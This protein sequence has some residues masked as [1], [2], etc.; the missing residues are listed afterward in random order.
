MSLPQG[1]NFR[2]SSGFVTDGT[3]E[4]GETAQNVSYPTTTP[5]GNN[6]GWESFQSGFAIGVRDR[7]A[8]NDRRLA[9]VH[10]SS[11]GGAYGIT[12]RIDLPA[13]GSYNIRGAFGDESNFDAGVQLE[14]FDGSTSLGV[15]ASNT[16]VPSGHWLDATGTDRSPDTDWAA[17]NVAV[18][19]TFATSILRFLLGTSTQNAV[20]AHF[21]VESGASA[22]VITAQPTQQSGAV[23]GTPTFGLTATGATS[24][25]WQSAPITSLYANVPGSWS[26]VVGATSSTYT[27]PALAS[28]DNGT[29]FRCIAT[30][31][32]GSTTSAPARVFVSGLGVAGKGG[33][34]FD[35]WLKRSNKLDAKFALR[36]RLWPGDQDATDGVVW[37]NW[38]LGVAGAPTVSA[39]I[40]GAFSVRN[41]AAQTFASAFSERNLASQ[42]LAG[43]FTVRAAVGTTFGGAFSERNF[44]A[45]T[46]AGAFSERNFATQTFAGAFSERNLASTTFAG[47]FSERAFVNTTFGAAFSERNYASQTQAAA[48]SQYN[49]ATATYAAAFSARNYATQGQ[50]AA[51]SVRNFSTGSIAGAFSERNFAGSTGAGSFSVRNAIA[52]AFNGAFSERAFVS[53]TDSAAFSVR[54]FVSGTQGGAWSIRNDVGG[55]FA[56]GF[57][58]Q[59]AGIVQTTWGSA[60][61]TRAFTSGSYAGAFSERVAAAGSQAG[62]FSV[63]NLTSGGFGSLFSVRAFMLASKLGAFSVRE[64][65]GSSSGYQ[66]AFTVRG[67]ASATIAGA[68]SVYGLAGGFYHSI[69][70]VEGQIL[71]QGSGK[72]IASARLDTPRIAAATMVDRTALAP[73]TDRTATA[74]ATDRTANAIFTLREASA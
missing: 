74:A 73:A 9:G 56:G 70:S 10:F 59:G 8:T 62:G 47:A 14:L 53:G 63:R 40:G 66:G 55:S 24:Y 7:D 16:A 19:K 34:G 17:N 64:L 44:V 28:G 29:W 46:F 6:V 60:F 72:R 71:S 48:W 33:L 32:I 13:S 41:F 36:K 23:G 45:Q 21:Y 61:S 1:I 42:T 22:P 57:T 30:N 67:T 38:V 15:L 5:Q 11:T 68:W 54:G 20:V 58:I 3:N 18:N 2:S 27:L 4:Y 69:F 35:G 12:Y 31:G 39:T 50:D 25:Q 52:A 65:V 49:F 43:S 51:F 26:N 37:S